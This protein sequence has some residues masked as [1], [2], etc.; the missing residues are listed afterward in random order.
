VN[1]DRDFLLDIVET[2]DAIGRHRPD[3]ESVFVDDKGPLTAVVHWIQTIGEAANGVTEELR[4]Q[5]PKVPWRQIVDVAVSR[6]IRSK[7]FPS[8]AEPGS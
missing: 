2:V 3:A 4:A 8:K 6:S 5:Y 7:V 1:R